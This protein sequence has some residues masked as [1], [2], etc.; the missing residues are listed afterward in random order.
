MRF[1]RTALALALTLPLPLVLAGAPL[2]LHEAQAADPASSESFAQRTLKTGRIQASLARL[3]A[4]R[5][6]NPDVRRFAEAVLGGLRA[7][8]ERL[9]R[10]VRAEGTKDV[11]EEV[12]EYSTH[13]IPQRTREFHRLRVR[14]GPAFDKQFL[15]A[16]IVGY[17][18][19]IRG[20]QAEAQSRN[21]DVRELA[22]ESLPKLR[23]QLEG[24]RLLLED[25][26]ERRR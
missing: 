4:Q 18:N 17:E 2:L 14:G 25:M 11:M 16:V 19:A 12:P 21:E 3:A 9:A 8:N 26:K 15:Q 7:R 1:A 10:I 24:A 13:E 6:E 5:A 23:G 20:Y 22:E